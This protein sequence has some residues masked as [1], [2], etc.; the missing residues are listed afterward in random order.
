MEAYKTLVKDLPNINACHLAWRLDNKTP[1]GLLHAARIARGEGDW[2]EKTLLEVFT[3]YERSDHSAKIHSKKVVD[4]SIEPKQLT[5]PSYTTTEILAMI[6]KLP[7]QN[8]I[9]NLAIE[10]DRSTIAFNYKGFDYRVFSFGGVVGTIPNADFLW[11]GIRS[12]R[13]R[14]L[15]Q[16]A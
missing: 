16:L 8:R 10:A 3:T 13:M 14:R 15:L 4:F 6:E 5:L 11:E 12:R 9:S 7:E 2:N 1:C